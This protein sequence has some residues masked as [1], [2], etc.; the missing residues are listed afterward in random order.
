LVAGNGFTI[1]QLRIRFKDMINVNGPQN[2][3]I[4]QFS[5]DELV[6]VL[7]TSM[8]QITLSSD[9]FVGPKHFSNKSFPNKINNL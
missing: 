7:F 8:V 9:D 6:L 3:V 2:T 5:A 1:I 4:H